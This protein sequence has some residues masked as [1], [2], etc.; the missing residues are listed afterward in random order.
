MREAGLGSGALPA[1]TPGSDPRGRW[2]ALGAHPGHRRS[3]ALAVPARPVAAA[4]CLSALLVVVSG[5]ALAVPLSTGAALPAA[6]A[7]ACGGTTPPGHVRV[8]VVVDD[9]TASPSARCFVLADGSTGADLLR[10]RADALGLPRPRYASS[11]LLCAV[12]GYPA[13]PACGE[14][15]GGLYQYWAYFQGTGG[16][17]TYGSS[18]NPFTRRLR[19]GDVEGWRFTVRGTAN[20]SADQPRVAPDPRVLFPPSPPPTTGALVPPAASAPAPTAPAG[21]GPGV[22]AASGAGPAPGAA[23]GAPGADD[24]AGSDP[25]VAPADPPVGTGDGDLDLGPGTPDPGAP[26][27]AGR[28]ADQVAAGPLDAEPASSSGAPAGPLVGLVVVAAVVGAAAVRF[29]VGSRP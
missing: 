27:G 24:R 26:A 20:G 18:V 28:P 17:W 11:G 23:A 16:S 25:G 1:P 4:V 22:D 2:T 6:A 14:V 15:V 19:D 9:G 7:Q 29:R 12:D 21:T 13:P 10:E 3:V 8:S 5:A